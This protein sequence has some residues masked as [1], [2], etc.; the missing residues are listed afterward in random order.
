ML[1]TETFVASLCKREP[2]AFTTPRLFS[3]VTTCEFGFAVAALPDAVDFAVRL[4]FFAE[5]V[6]STFVRRSGD[7]FD[8]VIV[9]EAIRCGAT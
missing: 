4:K 7:I 5:R 8:V 6:V 9:R 2:V 3:L 1:D